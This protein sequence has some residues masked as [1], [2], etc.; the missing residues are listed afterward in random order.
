MSYWNLICSYNQIN[1][2]IDAYK[3]SDILKGNLPIKN[4]AVL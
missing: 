1:F 4:Q 2:T 3:G